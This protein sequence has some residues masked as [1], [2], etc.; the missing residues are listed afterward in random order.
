[1]AVEPCESYKLAAE[2]NQMFPHWLAQQTLPTDP[3]M[4]QWIYDLLHS[5]FTAGYMRNEFG[6]GALW[7]SYAPECRGFSSSTSLHCVD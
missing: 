5:A 3:E 4:D 2:A 1:M 7:T 6:M